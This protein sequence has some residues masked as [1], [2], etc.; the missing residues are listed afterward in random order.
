MI[1]EGIIIVS[2]HYFIAKLNSSIKI[3]LCA[4]EWF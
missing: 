2:M 4:R 3:I 1:E